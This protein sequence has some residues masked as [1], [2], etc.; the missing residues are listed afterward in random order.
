[1]ASITK[2]KD[3]SYWR[4]Q[5]RRQGY[6]PLSRTFDTKLQAEAWARHVENEMDRGIFV[7]RTEAERTTLA[8]ALLRY[9]REIVPTKRHPA[10]ERQR[11]ARWLDYPF[12]KRSLANL[13]GA[14]FADYRDMRRAAGRAENT[15]RLELALI[16]HVFEIARKEWRM[17][18]LA[19]PLKDIRKPGGSNARDRRLLP[20]E[21]E[22]LRRLLGQ[23]G[24]K[25]AAAAMVLAVE[26]ALRQAMLF[27]LRW[28]WVNITNGVVRIPRAYQVVGNKG[29]PKVLHLSRRARRVMRLLHPRQ[30]DGRLTAMPSGPV[31]PTTQNAVVMAFKKAKA[32]HIAQSTARGQ[33]PMLVDLRW[34]DL[35]HEA[36]SRLVGKMKNLLHVRAITGHKSLQMLARYDHPEVEDLLAQLG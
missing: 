31:L 34:H 23:S 17:E 5:V 29:V 10:Q 25:F 18:G 26:T 11:I 14:D 22:L 35:R 33:S 16:S 21:F 28:E 1:M 13:R 20:G 36:C 9:Q 2:R 15:I 8:E 19:N 3:S 4:A 30:V 32:V 24:N 27:E 6:E 12:T 7:D